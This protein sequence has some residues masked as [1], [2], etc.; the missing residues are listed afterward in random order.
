VIG[1]FAERQQSGPEQLDVCSAEHR[2]LQGFEPVDLAFSLP[3]AP[4]LDHRVADCLDVDHQGLCEVDDSWN[5]AFLGFV[6]PSVKLRCA[7][8]W[9][10]S[11]PPTSYPLVPGLI[12]ATAYF[13]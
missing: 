5:A 12:D 13:A 8:R 11:A 6:E 7:Q 4:A 1:D 9:K 2:A 3:I 10:A